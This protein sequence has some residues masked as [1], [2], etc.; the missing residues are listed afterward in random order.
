MQSFLSFLLNPMFN[1]TDKVTTTKK[2]NWK[3]TCQYIIIHH[4][5]GNTYQGNLAR[6]SGSKWIVSCQFVIWP[7]GQSAKIGQPTDILRHAGDSDRG[8]LHFMNSYSMWIEVVWPDKHWGFSDIQYNKTIELIRYLMTTFKIP[9][10][11]ILCHH[12]ITWKWS[13]AMKLRDG[14]SPCRKPDIARSFWTDRGFKTF[15]AFRAS[16]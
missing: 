12:D 11:N 16:L 1:F 9:R 10:E 5:A 4:T 6:L 7:L 3:N 2:G 13:V 8:K 14:V 15:S